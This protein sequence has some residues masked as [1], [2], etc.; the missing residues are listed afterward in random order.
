MAM[1]ANLHLAG[2]RWNSDRTA[3]LAQRPGGPAATLTWA[4]GASRFERGARGAGTGAVVVR[5][6]RLLKT[7]R[8]GR[9]N[10]TAEATVFVKDSPARPELLGPRVFAWGEDFVLVL[11]KA[12]LV[13]VIESPMPRRDGSPRLRLRARIGLRAKPA[14]RRRRLFRR[15]LEGGVLGTGPYSNSLA[16]CLAG[17][18]QHAA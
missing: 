12:V 2:V 3:Q 13:L 5:G 8:K 15:R 10:M 16:L 11:S 18:V 7:A 4:P 14:L 6:R 17:G 1:E 9:S